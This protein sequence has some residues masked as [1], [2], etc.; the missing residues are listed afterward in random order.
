MKCLEFVDQ[1]GEISNLKR[2]VYFVFTTMTDKKIKMHRERQFVI[3]APLFA[4]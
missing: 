4:I 2:G 3:R 1:R